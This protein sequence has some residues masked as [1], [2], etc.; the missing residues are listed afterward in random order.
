MANSFQNQPLTQNTEEVSL[1]ETKKVLNE[2]ET[3]DL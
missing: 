3:K 2:Q 1:S